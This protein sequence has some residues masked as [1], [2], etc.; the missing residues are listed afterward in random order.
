[1]MALQRYENEFDVIII[2][3]NDAVGPSEPLF[4][5]PFYGQVARAL[6]PD[7]TCSVQG[8]STLDPEFLQQVQQRMANRLGP[9]IGYRLTIPSYHCGDYIFFVASNSRN[10]AGPDREALAK[11]QTTRGIATRYWSPELH[12][13]SQVLPKD[14]AL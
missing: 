4:E 10:P 1:M 11:L 12:H 6:R 9:T 2:D 5:E 14:S 3:C 7:G 13:A 8:G